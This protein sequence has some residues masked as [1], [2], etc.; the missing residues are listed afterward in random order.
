MSGAPPNITATVGRYSA[1]HLY[2]PQCA[3]LNDTGSTGDWWYKPQKKGNVVTYA[4]RAVI[5]NL[6]R[7]ASDF[8]RKKRR[9]W[10]GYMQ[11]RQYPNSI[12]AFRGPTQDT[13]GASS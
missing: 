10:F 2:Q 1:R 4:G 9:V 7:I 13:E 11:N 6:A 8:Y 12:E 5:E 3:W